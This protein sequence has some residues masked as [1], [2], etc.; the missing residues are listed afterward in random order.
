MEELPEE[1]LLRIFSFCGQRAT[2]ELGKAC[3]LFRRLSVDPFLV[4]E[5]GHKKRMFAQSERRWFFSMMTRVEVTYCFLSSSQKNETKKILVRGNRIK[6]F[7]R[8][9]SN[10]HMSPPHKLIIYYDFKNK[11]RP[12][13]DEILSTFKI[14]YVKSAVDIS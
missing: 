14:Y 11:I 12:K 13:D 4:K 6:D 5:F 7:R 2:F 1:V 3:T 8:D 10:T 9:V